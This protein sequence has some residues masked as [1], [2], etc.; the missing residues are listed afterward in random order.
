MAGDLAVAVIAAVRKFKAEN[1]ISLG[2][3]I[4]ELVI[5]TKDKKLLEPFLEDLKAV[6]KANS[7]VFEGNADIEVDEELKIGISP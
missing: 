3:E 7:I 4:K 5:D 1:N 2:Q 6:T